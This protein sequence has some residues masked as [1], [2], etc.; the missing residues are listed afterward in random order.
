MN[1]SKTAVH[2]TEAPAA[3]GPYSQAIRI[4]DFLFTSGQV[5]LD[6]GTGELVTGGIEEQTHQVLK[7]L[8]AVL[9]AA[10]LD[11]S[12]VVKTTVFLKQMSDFAAMNRIYAQYFQN[13]GI[14]PP[15]R[16]TIEVARLPK[17]GLIE[18]ELI[19]A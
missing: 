12:R 5:A 19:A 8:Q 9:A 4:G 7:N 14:S 15:A 18:I 1:V 17:D 10:S 11:L 2:S 16:S 13:E 3:I 6:P